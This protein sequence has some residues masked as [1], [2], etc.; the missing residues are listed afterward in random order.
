[1][2]EYEKEIVDELRKNNKKF[3]Q[4]FEE[5]HKLKDKVRDAGLGV[6]PLD[7]YTLENMKKKKLLVKDRMAAMIARYKQGQSN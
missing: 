1:M 4:L 7:D 5:H 3:E 2:F 6:L